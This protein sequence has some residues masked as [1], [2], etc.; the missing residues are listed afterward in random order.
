VLEGGRV[1]EIWVRG[2]SVA[3]RYWSGAR[4]EQHRAAFGAQTLDGQS[5]WL[6]T[7]DWGFFH[8]GE[9]FVSGRL[10]DLIII[11]GKKFSPVDVERVVEGADDRLRAGLTVA[12]SAPRQGEEQLVIV[13][14]TTTKLSPSARHEITA[15][16]RRAVSDELQ[17]LVGELCLVPSSSIPIT[18]SGKV[19]RSACREAF[20]AGAFEL[21]AP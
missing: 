18:S 17:L 10:K 1:G 5:P 11:R 20:I 6:R 14:A 3:T 4:A 13:G 12:F 7:G 2:A 21:E 8:A 19:R 9:L 16:V 15:S